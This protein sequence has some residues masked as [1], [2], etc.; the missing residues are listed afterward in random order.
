[1]GEDFYF[2]PDEDALTKVIK[3]YRVR[4]ILCGH[5]HRQYVRQCNGLT[6]LVGKDNKR[7]AGYYRLTRTR[8]HGSDL[9]AIDYVDLTDD[10]TPAEPIA[11]IDLHSRYGP[12]EALEPE[13]VR[14]RVDDD[15]LHVRVSQASPEVDGAVALYNPEQYNA[16][17]EDEWTSLSRSSG[18]LTGSLPVDALAPGQYRAIVRSAEGT[19]QWREIRPFEIGGPGLRPLWQLH[20]GDSVRGAAV[21]HGDRVVVAA[22][23]GEVAALSAG[24][25]GSRPIWTRRIGPSHH[26]P[27]V[28][29]KGLV[30]LA[31]PDHHLYALELSSGRQR[32]RADLG[33]PL[34]ADPLATVIDGQ[35]VVLVGSGRA[36]FC[37]DDA[38]SVMWRADLPQLVAGRPVCDGER[39]YFGCGDAN[40]YAVAAAT[41]A[42]VWTHRF[43]AGA[44]DPKLIQNSPY[45]ADALLASDELVVLGNRNDTLALARTTGEPVWSVPGNYMSCPPALVDG[46]VVVASKK[47]GEASALV[48]ENGTVRW[49]APTAP[50]IDNAAVLVA[51]T[52]VYV[53]SD[54]GI[55]TAVDARTGAAKRLGHTSG[56]AV[57][58]TPAL[59]R[60]HNQII[61]PTMDGMV[62]G[63]ALPEG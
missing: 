20:L 36:L 54:S 45:I 9:L 8:A 57:M 21:R 29:G 48:V 32:W 62:L 3:P 51:N 38:G 26:D 56:A 7:H 10:A 63:F 16:I 13:R 22:T 31:S 39:V 17:A 23:S 14:L 59:L 33:T 28:S 19:V 50:N 4:A 52:T 55:I 11:T 49:T 40:A 1:M 37:L 47:S 12:G 2:L 53:T 18:A 43:N 46:V 5:V 34:M 58:G 61:V 24:G 25:P 35:E 42:T 60:D 27:A 6:V 30:Y 41:G 44:D 15:R